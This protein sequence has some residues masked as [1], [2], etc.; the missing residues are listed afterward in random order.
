MAAN[1]NA[2]IIETVRTA[3]SADTGF[4]VQKVWRDA[5]T[6]NKVVVYPFIQSG[7]VVDTYEDGI[8]NSGRT[9]I[10]VYV[11][12]KVEL[13]PGGTTGK[14][15]A[16]W[17]DITERIEEAI[18]NIATPKHETHT[19]G[20]ETNIRSVNVIAQGGMLDDGKNQLRVEY[21]IEVLWDHIKN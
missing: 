14:A 12:A 21:S 1:R 9:L 17:D 13:D 7:A 5:F 18:F 2:F 4:A 10:T 8:V 19:S 16:T 3:L 15:T 6:D 20:N 11:N